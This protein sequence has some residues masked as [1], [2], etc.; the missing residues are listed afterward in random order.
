M[1][2]FPFPLGGIA[3]PV[4]S[5]ILAILPAYLGSK[6][7]V[8]VS[9]RVANAFFP[10]IRY[11]CPSNRSTF[12]SVGDKSLSLN[13]S[14]SAACKWR[15]YYPC[16]PPSN[17]PRHVLTHLEVTGLNIY[18]RSSIPDHWIVRVRSQRYIEERQRFLYSTL[19]LMYLKL[20]KLDILRNEIKSP[21]PFPSIQAKQHLRDGSP[22]LSQNDIAQ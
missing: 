3:F 7:R 5:T 9:I 11:I 17:P 6:S 8:I 19:F 13:K 16:D 20:S 1:L 2:T 15:Q 21:S 14:S 12:G 10:I 22:H 4:P 18:L